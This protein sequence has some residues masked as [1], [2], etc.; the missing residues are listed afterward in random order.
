M[1]EALAFFGNPSSNHSFG[2]EARNHLTRLRRET[3]DLLQV[4]RD[5]VIFTGNASE[6]NLLGLVGAVRALPPDR[7]HVL[8]TP[9]EHPSV[10]NTLQGLQAAAEIELTQVGVDSH[11]RVAV[12]RVLQGVR[13]STGLI[14]IMLA[15]NEIGTLEPVAEIVSALLGTGVVVHSDA[16]QAVGKTSRAF[17]EAGAHLSTLCPHKLGG[18]KGIGI[19]IRRPSVPLQSPLTIGRQEHGLRGGTESLALAAGAVA[20]LRVALDEEP[21]ESPR[22]ERLGAQLR[23]ALRAGFEEVKLHSPERACLPGLVNFSFPGLEGQWLVTALDQRGI[24]VSH[25]AACSSLASIPSHVLMAIGA[26]ESA[27]GAVRVSLGR[28][29]TAEHV[30][31][32][33][34]ELREVLVEIRGTKFF[35]RSQDSTKPYS[36]DPL[37]RIS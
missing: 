18:P 33:L 19:L 32:F 10:L 29:S 15:N 24:A 23:G 8:T 16:S 26:S 36:P 7:R 12:D 14:S 27:A 22:L 37:F 1:T 9:I 28:Y 30:S 5:A 11:G 34:S 4:E 17:S 35:F 25:G 31:R 2:R 20:A 3:A 6:A 13:K 21:A